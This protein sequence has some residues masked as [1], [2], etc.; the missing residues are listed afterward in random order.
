MHVPREVG[1]F[2]YTSDETR[3]RDVLESLIG[4]GWYIGDVEGVSYLPEEDEDGSDWVLF[5]TSKT[6]AEVLALVERKHSQGRPAGVVMM[7]GTGGGGAAFLWPNSHVLIV[8][9]NIARTRVPWPD[10][11]EAVSRIVRPLISSGIQVES[12]EVS[13]E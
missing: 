5:S 10:L 3:F 13:V 9:M 8:S 7:D 4:A 2:V 6:P 11:N 12:Y 1:V